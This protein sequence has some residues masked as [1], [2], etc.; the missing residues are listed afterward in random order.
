MEKINA[1]HN[2][3]DSHHRN[4]FGAVV[5]HELVTLRI[6]F[7]GSDPVTRCELRVWEGN[8]AERFLPMKLE[9]ASVETRDGCQVFAIDYR[10]P[11]KPGPVWYF[12]R[13]ELNGDF[14][15]YGNN[16]E[17]LGGEGYLQ[18]QEPH[19][20]Q[21][22]VFLPN[23]VPS[24]YKK[25][26][27]YQIYV[28]RFYH[29]SGVSSGKDIPLMAPHKGKGKGLLHLNWYDAP[30]Y[31]RDS[32][33]RIDR[34]TFFGGNLAGII[35]KLDYLRE[36]GVSVLYLNPIFESRSNH[37]YDTGDYLTIDPMYGDE[38]IFRRLV[39]E[40]D[41][42]GI[43]IILDGVFSHTGADSIYFNK[44]GTY[45]NLGAFQSPDSPYYDW[46]RFEEY[47][48]KYESW[49]D[50]DDLPNVNEMEPSYREFIFGGEN[51]VIQHWMRA[52]VKGWRLDVADELPDQFIKGLRKAL[53]ESDPEAVL[54]GEVWEDATNKVSYG[55]LREY[56]WGEELDA[57]MNYPLRGIWLDFILGKTGASMTHRRIMSLYENY[58]RENFYAAMNLIGSHDRVRILTLLGDAPP[59]DTLSEKE[60]ERHRLGAGARELA[61]ERL[62]LMV[63]LQMTFPGVPSIYYGDEVGLEGYSD[64]YNRG[65][66]PWGKEDRELLLWH[67]RM[68]RLRREYNVLVKGDFTS[69]YIDDDVYGFRRLGENGEMAVVLLNPG[70]QKA[71]EVRMSSLNTGFPL[72]K[73]VVLDLLEG[74]V[75]PAEG[76]GSLTVPPMDAKVLYLKEKGRDCLQAGSLPRAAGVLLS[77]TSLPSAWGVGDLGEGAYRFVDF[78]AEAGQKVWQI[79]PLNPLGSGNSPYQNPSLFAGNHILLGMDRLGEEGL[80]APEE[81]AMG[82]ERLTPLN[83]PKKASYNETAAVKERLLRKA[84]RNFFE[85]R[86]DSSLYR[87]Y[88]A[89]LKENAFWLDDYCLYMTAK[90]VL[91][92]I[93]WYRW[94]RGIAHRKAQDL[95]EFGRD[96]P[97]EVAYHGFVQ[98][99]FM[100]Q[101]ERLKDYA[102]DKGIKIVGDV[103]IYAAA[104]SC[105]TWANPHLFCLDENGE[106]LKVAGVPPDYFS[107]T[108]QLWGNP[109]YNWGE[110]E[111]DDYRWWVQRLKHTL[112]KVDYLRLDHFRGFEA[113]WEIPRDTKTADRGRWVKGP[114][115]RLFEVLLRELGE[116]P[117]IAEDLGV[118]TPEVFNLKHLFGLPGMKVFQFS[119][120]EMTA[121]K[122]TIFYTGTH[123]NDTLLGWCRDNQYGVEEGDDPVDLCRRIINRLYESEAP[124]VVVPLQDIL[125][126]DSAAR[127][128]VPG[129]ARGNWEWR[130]QWE[131]ITEET[132]AWLRKITIESRR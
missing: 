78:L 59:E 48:H 38:D 124:W 25:G 110:M 85:G 94:D 8:C 36:L 66:Y 131:Q 60:K 47:P 58:P 121:G 114:G 41:S 23:Q 104:D 74:E 95:E 84:F 28:D 42:R 45:S 126:L 103:P 113:Y 46:Y 75:L 1:Y 90:E 7:S 129:T 108:G 120:R 3:H 72:D 69:F 112:G 125:G 128:N 52:G 49:W 40:A 13:F 63:L 98:Y 109:L 43:K 82:L 132:I 107:E 19:G 2:T 10:V 57:T 100:R 5:C 67:Q 97:V 37:K 102:H 14:F 64:P 122:D 6:I 50:V 93:P 33:G 68:V 31:I 65:T 9:K 118:L 26:V 80:L 16:A 21:I 44:E 35:A 34:W 123:D 101:W 99:L 4:P 111:K 87:G 79:L 39:Q 81:L 116:L 32:K 127:M 71:K 54:I 96:H 29:G 12:F 24:W 30:F 55:E 77:V 17:K 51:S 53:K 62:K 27:I 61:K 15:Y 76:K 56:F 92:D 22:T 91:G 119:H 86:L 20:F 115:K 117:L 106:P 83:H 11:E 88:N 130:F 70:P 18:S 73:T 105:D 89:F